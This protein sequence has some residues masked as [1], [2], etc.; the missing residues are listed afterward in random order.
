[1]PLEAFLN[2][3]WEAFLHPDDFEN[4]AKAFFQSIQTGESFSPSEN[5]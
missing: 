3:G 2:L 5:A 1:M 4:T